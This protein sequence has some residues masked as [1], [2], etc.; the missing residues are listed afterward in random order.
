MGPA[1]SL[2]GPDYFS[3]AREAAASWPQ[4][5]LIVASLALPDNRVEMGVYQDRLES[6]GPIVVR[7]G[8]GRAVIGIKGYEVDLDGNAFHE[9]DQRPGV[10]V[11]VVDP[12]Q[13]HVLEGDTPATLKRVGA[14]RFHEGRQRIFL[15]DRHDEAARLVVG[16]VERNG[17][18]NQDFAA[19][20][21]DHVGDARRRD[22]HVPP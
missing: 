8:K 11:G 21:D 6:K 16:G 12:R 7:T 9:P 2:F 18:V 20:P 3:A 10:V 19:E 5:A 14:Q 1:T 15:I 13:Q 22:G 4:A 17:K